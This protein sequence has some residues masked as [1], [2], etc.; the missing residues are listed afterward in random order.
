[1]LTFPDSSRVA[2]LNYN[3]EV[4]L[5][6]DHTWRLELNSYAVQS[7]RV[8][9]APG[10]TVVKATTT[11]DPRLRAELE[12]K[13]KAEEALAR[14][15]QQAGDSASAKAFAAQVS[16]VRA[17]FERGDYLTVETNLRG[18]FEY[19]IARAHALRKK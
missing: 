10:Q 2:D 1:M 4:K 16:Q 15:L 14:R 3:R 11:I 7:F 5:T 8:E 12:N 6:A 18:G 9:G 19:Q 13:L 17:V